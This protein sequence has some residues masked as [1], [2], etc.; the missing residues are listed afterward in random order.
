MAD[1]DDNETITDDVTAES[2]EP[3]V[4]GFG[5]INITRS[6]IKGAVVASPTP[7]IGGIGAGPADI[8]IKENGIK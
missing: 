4:E 3:E 7:G 5:S 6:N 1:Q 8:A 2:D